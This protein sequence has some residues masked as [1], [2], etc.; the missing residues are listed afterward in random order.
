[1]VDKHQKKYVSNIAQVWIG[2]KCHVDT[3]SVITAKNDCQPR[4]ELSRTSVLSYS[5]NQ[6]TICYLPRESIK[7]LIDMEPFP[8]VES[9]HSFLRALRAFLFGMNF[10]FHPSS[11]CTFACISTLDLK[12]CFG[13]LSFVSQIYG[14]NHKMMS[15]IN[16]LEEQS[17]TSD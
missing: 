8:K 16:Q 17:T 11:S 5:L 3:L 12:K 13:T 9:C 14:Y 10:S 7:S 6:Q 15:Y 4:G 1:M 2:G